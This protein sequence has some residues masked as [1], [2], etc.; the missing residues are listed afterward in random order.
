MAGAPPGHEPHDQG[1]KLEDKRRH[2]VGE[3]IEAQGRDE[4]A[5][6][7]DKEPAVLPSVYPLCV[8]PRVLGEHRDTE[9]Q[10]RQPDKRAHSPLRVQ[11]L[12]QNNGKKGQM[13]EDLCATKR[14]GP[15]YFS[16]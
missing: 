14:I 13:E 1:D 5:Q 11:P 8:A 6:P 7:R 2:F 3:R 4:L 15:L 9:Q 16:C 10:H 12:P